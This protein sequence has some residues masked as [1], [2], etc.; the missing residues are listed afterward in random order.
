MQELVRQLTKHLNKQAAAAAAADAAA[1]SPGTPA[2][3]QAPRDAS[4]TPKDPLVWTD[5]AKSQKKTPEATLVLSSGR[6]ST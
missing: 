4:E 2:T 5:A 6:I 3:P 1:Q